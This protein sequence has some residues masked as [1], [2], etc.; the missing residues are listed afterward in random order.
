MLGFSPSLLTAQNKVNTVVIDA[1]HGG[2]QPGTSGKYTREKDITL[3]VALKLG[4][5]IEQNMKEVKV[6]YTRTKDVAVG[7]DERANIANDNHA[8]VFISIHANSLPE[9]TPDERKQAIYG[10]ETYVM[11]LHVSEANFEVAKRENSAMYAEENYEEKYEGFD[12]NSP[13]SYILLNLNQSAN[14]EGSILLASKIESQLK[15]KA[16]RK[17]KGVKQAGFLVLWKTTMPSVLVEIGYL[18]NTKEEKELNDDK[19][20]DYIASAIYRA[21]KEYKA[22]MDTIN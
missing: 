7:F 18:S 21:F 14:A 17:S 12:P 4:A 5:Y 13:E 9:E 11:G 19:V 20:Q 3:K 1:G 10:T 22:Q 8:D 6:L 16:G 15:L 2:R